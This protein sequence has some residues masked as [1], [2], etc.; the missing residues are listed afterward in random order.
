[1]IYVF[2]GVYS[3]MRACVSEWQRLSGEPSLFR[4]ATR[5]SS[6]ILILSHR[7]RRQEKRLGAE[8][9]GPIRQTAG[10]W[11][12]ESLCV[13]AWTSSWI[14]MNI[15]IWMNNHFHFFVLKMLCLWSDR[16]WCFC[17]RRATVNMKTRREEMELKR[18][19][20]RENTFT[21]M[22][23]VIVRL[24]T[25]FTCRKAHHPQGS[26]P[27]QPKGT[28]WAALRFP[29]GIHPE[30]GRPLHHPPTHSLARPL[31][32]KCSPR[33]VWPAQGVWGA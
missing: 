7:D 23:K 15:K 21:E 12:S 14:L 27:G 33:S 13:V 30:T 10:K 32:P 4:P 28:G 11:R 24:M 1:M 2:L 22:Y 29:G 3:L 19:L 31:S 5:S 16:V 6:I 8:R 17:R 20:L 26:R 18:W 9:C 25:F